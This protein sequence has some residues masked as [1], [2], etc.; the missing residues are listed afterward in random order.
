MQESMVAV[1]RGEH[2]RAKGEEQGSRILRS[3]LF[4]LISPNTLSLIQIIRSKTAFH[5]S[6]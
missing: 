1:L 3:S 4:K 6:R 5:G 2:V